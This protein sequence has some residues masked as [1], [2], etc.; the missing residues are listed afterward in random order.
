MSACCWQA[1]ER[2]IAHR[3]DCLKCHV[4]GPLDGPFVVLLQEQGTDQSDDGVVV[5]EDA[6]DFSASLD[7]AVETLDRICRMKL[8]LFRLNAFETDLA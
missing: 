3:G 7:L 2:I 5:G 4:A 6:N 1:D 8:C